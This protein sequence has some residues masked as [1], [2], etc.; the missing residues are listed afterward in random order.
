LN[1]SLEFGECE[2]VDKERTGGRDMRG[3]KEEKEENTILNSYVVL[4][5][6][7]STRLTKLSESVRVHSLHDSTHK[8]NR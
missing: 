1:E 6:S 2:T 5:N 4:V 8:I 3:E 7:G